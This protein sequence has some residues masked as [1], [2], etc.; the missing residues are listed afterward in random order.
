VT[1]AEGRARFIGVELAC[2][3]CEEEGRG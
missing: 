1:T 3:R 2:K